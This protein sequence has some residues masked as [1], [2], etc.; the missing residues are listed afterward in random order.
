MYDVKRGVRP[1]AVVSPRLG[2]FAEFE[3]NLRCERQVEEFAAAKQRGAYGG[4][5][6]TAPRAL[7][8]VGE[9][10]EEFISSGPGSSW[11][12]NPAT[13]TGSPASIA[14]S[15]TCHRCTGCL[16]NRPNRSRVEE[17]PARILERPVGVQVVVER[18]GG[19]VADLAADIRNRTRPIDHQVLGV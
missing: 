8:A 18:A 12:M 5:L 6:V 15:P 9:L 11:S 2:V 19:E 17:P 7:I 14:W 16:S 1:G 10:H 4:E 3:T 13:V